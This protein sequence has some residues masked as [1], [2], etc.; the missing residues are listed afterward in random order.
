MGP[1]LCATPLTVQ[2]TQKAMTQIAGDL[3]LNLSLLSR[4]MD[5]LDRDQ[6]KGRK[7][8]GEGGGLGQ[9]FIGC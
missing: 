1:Q 2:S 8:G 4:K 7:G 3:G 6:R 5:G 9:G